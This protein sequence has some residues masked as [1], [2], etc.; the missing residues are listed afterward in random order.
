[1][2]LVPIQI[3][4]DDRAIKSCVDMIYNHVSSVG[5]PQLSSFIFP[6]RISSYLAL[7]T[8]SAY[9]LHQYSNTSRLEFLLNIK[10]LTMALS[11]NGIL[12]VFA[13]FK[14]DRSP[15]IHHHHF[16]SQRHK[17]HENRL[18]LLN[19]I[20]L[21]LVTEAS[22]DVAAVCIT[23]HA[24]TNSRTV[25]RVHVMKNRSCTSEEM[26]Y[27]N[28]FVKVL[29][30]CVASKLGEALYD[31]VLKNCRQQ[32]IARLVQL[33]KVVEEVKDQISTWAEPEKN[34]LD[35]FRNFYKSSTSNSSWSQLLFG[36]LTKELYP[37][38]L[39]LEN[40][41]LS[42]TSAYFF[43]KNNGLLNSMRS[44][45]LVEQLRNVSDYVAIIKRIT[46]LASRERGRRVFELNIVS[47]ELV[48]FS[49]ALELVL[50]KSQLPSPPRITLPPTPP[51]IVLINQCVRAIT[52][53]IDEFTPQDLKVVLQ[54]ARE[55][56]IQSD[57]PAQ[58][59]FVHCECALAVEMRRFTNEPLTIGVSE[60][61]CWP[62][63]QFLREFS[64]Q[65]GRITVPKCHG[66][67][68]SNWLFPL[69]VSHP[70]HEKVEYAAILEFEA[71]VWDT[72]EVRL[73]HSSHDRL[74]QRLW[75]MEWME[76][77]NPSRDRGYSV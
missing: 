5:N 12:S 75:V 18:K 76:H 62:C 9:C 69:D 45:Q 61:S 25:T 8:N 47:P 70:L 49:N 11:L 13:T 32:I 71:W 77:M 53:P 34:D 51:P 38:H 16:S 31:V 26:E 74:K 59:A 24:R 40:L 52:W 30:E 67:T 17:K 56:D 72:H 29:N 19:D 7:L 73:M 46:T 43:V 36:F 33:Q 60:H 54:T 4:I 10:L 68:D 37:S 64:S 14:V 1:M 50:I 3:Y 28:D 21:L 35:N 2:N 63:V 6:P 39:S 22:D 41:D 27:F 66:K 44:T 55:T 65:S 58:E 15:S 20:A 57:R 23:N 42:L 48:F